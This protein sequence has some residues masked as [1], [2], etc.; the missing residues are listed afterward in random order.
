VVAEEVETLHD[1]FHVDI[2]ESQA[3]KDGCFVRRGVRGALKLLD[4][5]DMVPEIVV[6]EEQ[7]QADDL[8]SC[9]QRVDLLLLVS[10]SPGTDIWC[11]AIVE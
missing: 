3:F 5:E 10:L 11:A 1:P 7:G 8:D 2:S 4:G 6:F 9:K